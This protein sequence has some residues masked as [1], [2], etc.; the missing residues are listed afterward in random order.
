MSVCL[1]PAFRSEQWLLSLYEEDAS[2]DAK[3][4]EP[5]SIAFALRDGACQGAR[6]RSRDGPGGSPGEDPGVD[7][8]EADKVRIGVV[9]V[10][11]RTGRVV[12][13]TFVE[14]SGQRRELDTR[15]RHLR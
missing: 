3:P 12:H 2:S 4:G 14:T 11:V 13:D 5:V 8:P 7:G 6:K 15:V 9:A 10:D 1:G